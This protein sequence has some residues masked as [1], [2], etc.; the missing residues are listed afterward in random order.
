MRKFAGIANYLLCS[1]VFIS[2]CI[3][4]AARTSTS[5]F[6]PAPET[7][8]TKTSQDGVRISVAPSKAEDIQSYVTSFHLD[9]QNN[10]GTPITVGYDD[11]ALFD[12]NR[13]Q[14]NALDPQTVAQI[15]HSAQTSNAGYYP[16]VSVGVGGGYSTGGGGFLSL[17]TFFDIFRLFR[18]NRSETLKGGEILAHS[19]NPG[20]VNPGSH[21][22]GLVY[23]KRIPIDA[24]SVTLEISY[25]TNGEGKR[26][27]L[28]FPFAV[29]EDG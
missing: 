26:E 12:E 13:T 3:G 14:Y 25:T 2:L 11:I 15:L 18:G 29:G 6:S 22:S 4:C 21:K 7:K 9:I 23:F 16:N 19:L 5:N 10:S 28:S 24:G 20:T 8:S 17:G 27:V 1:L